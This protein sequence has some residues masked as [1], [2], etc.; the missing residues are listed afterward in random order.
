MLSCLGEMHNA[1]LK[2]VF[3]DHCS[4]GGQLCISPRTREICCYGSLVMAISHLRQALFTVWPDRDASMQVTPKHEPIVL[5]E[6]KV[7]AVLLPCLYE[8][9]RGITL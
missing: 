5:S 6:D 8:N 4:V 2:A 3:G 9:S 1:W 7:I